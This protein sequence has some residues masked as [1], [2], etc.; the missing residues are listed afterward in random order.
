MAYHYVLTW[1][2]LASVIAT[3]VAFGLIGIGGRADGKNWNEHSCLSEMCQ[4]C[5]GKFCEVVVRCLVNFDTAPIW[6]AFKNLLKQTLPSSEL[7]GVG[8]DQRLCLWKKEAF[9]ARLSEIAYIG[10]GIFLNQQEAHCDKFG[11]WKILRPQSGGKEIDFEIKGSN[12]CEFECVWIRL[13]LFSQY[14][15]LDFRAC[16]KLTSQWQWVAIIYSIFF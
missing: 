4:I 10:C 2:L 1:S 9:I 11:K 13:L 6:R 16:Q 8:R 14:Q 7:I 15:Y 3:I 5:G 12:I